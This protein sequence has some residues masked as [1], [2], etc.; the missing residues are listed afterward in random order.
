MIAKVYQLA[1]LTAKVLADAA[2]DVDRTQCA[3][4]AAELEQATAPVDLSK[5][6]LRPVTMTLRAF[7]EHCA[8]LRAQDPPDRV[9]LALAQHNLAQVRKQAPSGADAV[10]AVL[11]LDAAAAAD[12]PSLE[13]RLDALEQQLAKGIPPMINTGVAAGP[14]VTASPTAA[15]GGAGAAAAAAPTAIALAGEAI[16]S[17]AFKLGELKARFQGGTITAQDVHDLFPDYNLRQILDQAIAIVGKDRVEAVFPGLIA[18]AADPS[19]ADPATAIVDP[20]AD[21]SADAPTAQT[22]PTTKGVQTDPVVVARFMTGQSM[23]RALTSEEIRTR[24]A[25]QLRRRTPPMDG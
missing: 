24:A 22:T 4:L 15:P 21:L 2:T 16:E 12:G 7:Q 8:A 9:A 11:V 3:A 20:P 23:S 19:L 5:L 14:P 18:M 10:V 13:A 25:K 1:A 17:A 6:A